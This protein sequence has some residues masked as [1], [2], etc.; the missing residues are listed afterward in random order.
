MLLGDGLREQG[1]D[2][3]VRARV[4]RH[5][6]RQSAQRIVGASGRVP[7]TLDRF[8]GEADGLAGRG[9]TSSAVGQLG[10]ARFELAIVRWGGQKGPQDLKA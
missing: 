3:A 5:L 4:R 9:V 1:G 6:A 8:E 10:D 7:P 2:A